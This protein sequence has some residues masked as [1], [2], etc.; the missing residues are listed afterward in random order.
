VGFGEVVQP[1]NS[2]CWVIPHEQDGTGAVF[3]GESRSQARSIRQIFTS[4]AASVKISIG[5]FR[6]VLILNSRLAKNTP[7]LKFE[8]VPLEAVRVN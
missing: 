1:V 6:A 3:H 2:A 4:F 5:V 7:L 8:D